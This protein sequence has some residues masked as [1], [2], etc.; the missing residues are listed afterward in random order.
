MS[1]TLELVII[2]FLLLFSFTA[3]VVYSKSVKANFD[4]LF[5]VK[6]QE[7]EVTPERINDIQVEVEP[8]IAPEEVQAIEKSPS[9]IINTEVDTV[10]SVQEEV[11]IK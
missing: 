3:G 9:E 7:I 2:L 8:I 6:E 4:W 10:K 1:K 11:P 5:E